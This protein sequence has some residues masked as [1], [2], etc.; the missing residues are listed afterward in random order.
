MSSRPYRCCAVPLCTNTTIKSP[1]KL[2]I[3]VPYDKTIRN[4]WLKL[5]RRDIK[6]ILP[7]TQL[8]FCEDHFDVSIYLYL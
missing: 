2:F 6:G 7:N 5:A 8:Y 1:D 4:K 3:F